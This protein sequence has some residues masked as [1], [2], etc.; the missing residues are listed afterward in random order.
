MLYSAPMTIGARLRQLRNKNKLSQEDIGDICGVSKAM[1]SQ[2]ESDLVT[3]PTD[4]LISLH[5][6]V[7]F[8]ADWLL[9]GADREEEL[10]PP[11]RALLKVAESLPAYAV[12]KLAKEGST[13]AELIKTSEDAPRAKP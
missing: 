2:W 6:E 3:P 7:N 13:Y 11:L 10:N 12:E 4:R 9:F 8:S 5:K 1:V